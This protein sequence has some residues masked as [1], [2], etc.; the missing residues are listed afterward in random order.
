MDRISDKEEL[1][2]DL[3]TCYIKEYSKNGYDI[4]L[5]S[6]CK[7][8]NDEINVEKLLNIVKKHK[9]TTNIS[10]KIIM[11]VILIKFFYQ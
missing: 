9:I 4:I 5:S 1:Y 10:V 6:F 2:L 8:E 7:A 11:E 3:L